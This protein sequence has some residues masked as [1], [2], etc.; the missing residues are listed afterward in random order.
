MKDNLKHIVILPRWYPNKTDIQLGIFIQRQLILLKDDLKLTVVYAQQLDNTEHKFE[1]IKNNRDKNFTELLIYFKSSKGI[2]KKIINFRRFRKAQK[3]GLKQIEAEIDAFHIQVPYRTAIP[4][5]QANRKFNTPFFVT[6]HWSGHL[7][8]LFLQK[9][10]IDKWLYRFILK[11][12]SKIST[13]STI[14]QS[15]FKANTGFNSEL[16][17]NLIEKSIVDSSQN[18][19]DSNYINILSV[20]DLIDETKNQSSLLIAFKIALNSQKNLRL[21]L[22]GGGP[23]E[24]KIRKLAK[25]LDLQDENLTFAGRQN[26]EYVLAAMNNCDFYICNSRFE[27]FGMTVAEAL[28][29][30]KPVIST[31]CGGPEEFLN[32][33]NSIQIDV[34]GK[35]SSNNSNDFT[36]PIRDYNPATDNY[37][38][39]SQAINKMAITYPDYNSANI[40]SQ[41]EATFGKEAIRQKWLA[42]YQD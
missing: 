29:C 13:V 30:G 32:D 34:N 27:T 4:A 9:N 41:I 5:L 26:H 14:L 35:T 11:R 40:S 16:I 15:K 24:E 22:I 2:F 21:T 6:E 10:S 39:L 12:A 38:E 25:D 33:S 37:I 8:G 28:M 17:P 36:L 42:F 20:A 3:L 19:I 31:R 1:L 7:N 18:T 23:D